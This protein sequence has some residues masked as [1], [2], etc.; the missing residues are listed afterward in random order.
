MLWIQ[1]SPAPSHQHID[2][3]AQDCG[4]PSVSAVELLQYITMMPHE[5]P[6][7]SNHWQLYCLYRHTSKKTSKLH[8]TGPSW[9]ESTSDQWIAL[10]NKGQQCGKSFHIITSSWSHWCHCKENTPEP[11]LFLCSDKYIKLSLY[12]YTI[13]LLTFDLIKIMNYC[14]QQ[15]WQFA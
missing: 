12:F 8:V 10:N 2:G 11:V 3:L 6:G 1:I 5:H 7:V 14:T 9:G 4:N 13:A 15:I